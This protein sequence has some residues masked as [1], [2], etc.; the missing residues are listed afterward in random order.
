MT[1]VLKDFSLK[2]KK[3][4]FFSFVWKFFFG[5]KEK[6]KT[7]SVVNGRSSVDDPTLRESEWSRRPG[8]W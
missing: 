7:T 5:K 3:M 1:K 2:G 6:A 8:A 4:K